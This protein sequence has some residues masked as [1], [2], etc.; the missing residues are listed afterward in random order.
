MK[1]LSAQLGRNETKPFGLMELGIRSSQKVNREE[2]LKRI[3]EGAVRSEL[4]PPNEEQPC[5]LTKEE[6]EAL[7]KVEL[8]QRIREG[9]AKTSLGRSFF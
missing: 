6:V 8:R 7:L 1:K 4:E 2:I 5:P 9:I 3:E